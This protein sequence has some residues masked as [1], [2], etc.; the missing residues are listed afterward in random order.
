MKLVDLRESNIICSPRIWGALNLN[1]N[2]TK[3]KLTGAENYSNRESLQEQHTKRYLMGRLSGTSKWQTK[4]SSNCTRSPH[5]VLTTI[6]SGKKTW[7]WWRIVNSLLSNRPQ[8]ACSW[9]ALVDRTS[10]GRQTNWHEHVTD[11]WLFWFRTFKIR[12]ITDNVA[13]GYNGSALSFGFVP[14][15]RSCLGL[16]RTRNQLHNEKLP[17]RRRHVKI[18]WKRS[19]NSRITSE[20]LSTSREWR[21]QQRISRKLGWVSTSRYK[22]WRRSPQPKEETFPIPL[23]NID[24]T[25]SSHTNLVVMQEIRTNNDYWN[26][27]GDRTVSDS[28]TGFSMFTLSNEKELKDTWG[29][30]P[31]IWIG[32]SKAVKK[33]S[34]REWAFEKPKLDNA[35]KL[36][37][38]LLH[39]SRWW[40]V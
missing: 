26:V 8:N 31:E 30:E 32:M 35:Q 16:L 29:P 12:V 36:R 33:Q 24:V 17:N 27:G 39:R 22:K 19:W 21:S 34:K 7:K 11:A 15:P 1:A 40:R 2:R 9:H 6:S 25:R 14:R 4:Q 10:C 23:K 20:A 13:C 18:A 5:H 3:V 37:G 38:L 28:W